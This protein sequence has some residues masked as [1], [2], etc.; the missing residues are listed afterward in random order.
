MD[1][2]FDK[3]KFIIYKEKAEEEFFEP[4]KYCTNPPIEI[5][6]LYNKM[7]DT[8]AKILYLNDYPSNNLK[9]FYLK[10]FKDLECE[11]TNKLFKF[12]YDKIKYITIKND[13]DPFQYYNDQE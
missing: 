3:N 12:L 2:Y 11:F 6:D 9:D 5:K 1:L 4:L 10:A 13:K 7:V 8:K